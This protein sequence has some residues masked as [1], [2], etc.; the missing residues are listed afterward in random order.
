M[1]NETK[2]RVWKMDNKSAKTVSE[3]E[4][5]SF[6]PNTTTDRH[7]IAEILAPIYTS[8]VNLSGV[9]LIDEDEA[10][11]TP[12]GKEVARILTVKATEFPFLRIFHYYKCQEECRRFTAKF[13]K[14][15]DTK[16]Y[17]SVNADSSRNKFIDPWNDSIFFSLFE[18]KNGEVASTCKIVTCPKCKGSGKEY[19][20]IKK[21]KDI[22]M[23][24]PS[25]GGTGEEGIYICKECKGRG[26]IPG[27]RT[28]SQKQECTCDKCSGK[29]K[30]K[31]VIVAELSAGS[32]KVGVDSL[33]R[34][35]RKQEEKEKVKKFEEVR[36][37][38]MLEHNPKLYKPRDITYDFLDWSRLKD[39]ESKKA[40]NIKVIRTI[41]SKGGVINPS[42]NNLSKLPLASKEDIK[43]VY[44]ECYPKTG[45]GVFTD[46]S[47][48][49]ALVLNVCP[50]GF[51]RM[52]DKTNPNVRVKCF[53]EEI[54]IVTGVGWVKLE[55]NTGEEVWVNALNKE[56]KMWVG[57]SFSRERDRWEIKSP[58]YSVANDGCK[59]RITDYDV[60]VQDAIQ[61]AKRQ[62]VPAAKIGSRGAAKSSASNNERRD[63]IVGCGCLLALVAIVGFVGWWWWE[64]FTMAAL[65]SM[66][67]Q[68]K[69][70]LGCSDSALKTCAMIG[71]GLVALLVLFRLIKGGKSTG[72]ASDKKRWKFV[73]L[74]LLFGC[75]GIHLAYAKRWGLFALLWAALVFG[76][77]MSKDKPAEPNSSSDP[78]A[79]V[80]AGQDD[81]SKN[82]PMQKHN[83]YENIGMGIWALLWFGGALLIKKDGNGNRM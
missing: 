55:L 75:L 31:S 28:I 59:Y 72:Q 60:V 61:E 27:I 33:S 12:L 17:P 48:I 30:V 71:G 21:E 3:K 54:K 16:F 19:H 5:F 4:L 80:V 38:R 34:D 53:D 40:A 11:F 66:W 45:K 42:K 25:C 56:T 73:V 37:I 20:D 24:C 77:M 13:F 62:G 36:W 83:M 68:T 49:R 18:N 58:L 64:G 2:E 74:G 79:E 43:R 78:T 26:S 35:E 9:R 52:S 67:A 47:T 22:L 76:G 41:S 63:S 57:R 15:D 69:N 81:D 1:E 82:N 70:S 10:I 65:S 51:F 29:G 14:L 46:A 6:L 32:M 23:T 44:D 8:N 50:S 39:D 7:R